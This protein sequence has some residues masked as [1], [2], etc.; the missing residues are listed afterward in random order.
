M[1][2][3]WLA[4]AL[5]VLVSVASI[6][7]AARRG[8]ALFRDFKRLSRELRDGLDRIARS[9]DEL[10]L[11]LRAAATSGSALEASLARLRTSRSVLGVLTAALAEVRASAGRITA[12]VPRSK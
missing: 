5:F 7:V 6:V 10:E 11:H 1:I 4:L 12:V 9:T 2:L 8:L 3:F